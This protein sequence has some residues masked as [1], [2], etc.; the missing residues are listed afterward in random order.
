MSNLPDSYDPD[1]AEQRW[2]DHW[3]ESDVYAYDDD[4]EQIG[5][6]HV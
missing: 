1:E 6:A 4:P 2:R 5:R 3:Q